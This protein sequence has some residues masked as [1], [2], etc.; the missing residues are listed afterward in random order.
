VV[1]PSTAALDRADKLPIYGR[2]GVGH[3]WLVDPLAQT[4]EVF[5]QDGGRWLLL[6]SYK[7]DARVRVEP[8]DAIDLDLSVLGRVRS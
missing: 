1:S 2:A 6:G 5:K 4:L 7:D 8:F 3:A